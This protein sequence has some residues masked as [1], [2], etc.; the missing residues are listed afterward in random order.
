MALQETESNISDEAGG[1]GPPSRPGAG[2]GTDRRFPSGRGWLALAMTALLVANSVGISVVAAGAATP[3][4][5]SSANVGGPVSGSAPAPVRSLAPSSKCSDDGIAV[6]SKGDR[7]K[8]EGYANADNESNRCKGTAVTIPEGVSRVEI[9]L[10]KPEGADFDLFATL[11]GRRPSREDYDRKAAYVDDPTPSIVLEPSDIP[12]DRTIGVA[13]SALD[14]SGHFAVEVSPLNETVDAAISVSNMTPKV[15]QPIRI[16]GSDTRVVKGEARH[17]WTIDG[18]EVKTRK[19]RFKHTFEEAGTHTVTL[20]V[21]GPNGSMDMARKKIKVRGEEKDKKVDA[22]LDV[23]SDETVWANETIGLSGER[24]SAKAGV[25]R[26]LWRISDGTKTTG[27]TIQHTFSKP[28]NYTVTLT[29]IDEGVG[30]DTVEKTI[31]VR[32]PNIWVK[33]VEGGTTRVLPDELFARC[34]DPVMADIAGK[35]GVK[36]VKF[37]IGDR[38]FVDEFGSDGWRVQKS[39]LLRGAG[40]S[41]VLRI[42]AVG[43]EGSTDVETVRIRTAKAPGSLGLI[44]RGVTD[45]ARGAQGLL[46]KSWFN[47]GMPPVVGYRCKLAIN[48]PQIASS[49]TGLPNVTGTNISLPK[50]V[51]RLF[52][53]VIPFTFYGKFKMQYRPF[54]DQISMGGGMGLSMKINPV[55]ESSVKGGGDVSGYFAMPKWTLD[56]FQAHAYLAADIYLEEY[57]SPVPI[58]TWRVDI[59][60]TNISLNID[61]VDVRMSPRID[62]VG[63]VNGDFELQSF[64]AGAKGKITLHGQLGDSCFANIMGMGCVGARAWVNGSL[65]SNYIGIVPGEDERFDHGAPIQGKAMTGSGVSIRTP[66]ALIPDYSIYWKKEFV[67]ASA[68]IAPSGTNLGG[69]TYATGDR[70]RTT[71]EREVTKG[72]GPK[73]SSSPA[74]SLRENRDEE[75]SAAVASGA[76]SPA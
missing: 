4:T 33:D 54:Q 12:A 72:H 55:G 73:V 21:K 69:R 48:Y 60:Y 49:I 29:V 44:A 28:G 52:P 68:H 66:T 50:K 40:R 6:R 25:D 53:D 8:L 26:Y 36:H 45:I 32:R 14:G 58:P 34:P 2:G 27:A 76:L 74:A 71:V 5:G 23:L 7:L 67:L 43:L 39:R 65:E 20:R 70:I 15:G 38:Q 13:V 3:A 57:V 9:T 22:E 24:S 10:H 75:V 63:N 64:G 11:D 47:L 18:E 42:T 46:N 62:V 17:M 59:P 31:R 61:P 1:S 41:D 35:E 37:S 51:T 19:W 16:D 56:R 30:T